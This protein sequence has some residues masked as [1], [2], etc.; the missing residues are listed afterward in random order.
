MASTAQLGVPSWNGGCGEALVKTHAITLLTPTFV[1]KPFG[2]SHV[3]IQDYGIA[4]PWLPAA[5]FGQQTAFAAK[6]LSIVSSV[7][8]LVRK[9][10]DL[11]FNRGLFLFAR[12]VKA[13]AIYVQSVVVLFRSIPLPYKFDLPPVDGLFQNQRS[14]LLLASVSTEQTSAFSQ[15]AVP[16]LAGVAMLRL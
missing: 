9:A 16:A 8:G 7:S 13:P 14:C 6:R 12:G 3:D 2:H 15:T 11:L 10:E 4:L 1:V 5:C